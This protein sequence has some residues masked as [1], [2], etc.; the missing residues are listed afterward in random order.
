METWQYKSM[1]PGDRGIY[2][3]LQYGL[4]SS[5]VKKDCCGLIFHPNNIGIVYCWLHVTTALNSYS[6]M[7]FFVY[8]FGCLL[9]WSLLHIVAMVVWIAQGVCRLSNKGDEVEHNHR[10]IDIRLLASV[11]SSCHTNTTYWV[12]VY[13]HSLHLTLLLGARMQVLVLQLIVLRCNVDGHRGPPK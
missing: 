9:Y 6:L 5:L 11:L 4:Q 12:I 2:V 1:V 7:N 13:I 3:A 8:W 10:R